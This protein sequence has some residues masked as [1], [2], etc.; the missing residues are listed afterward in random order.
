MMDVGIVGTVNRHWNTVSQVCPRTVIDTV[1]MAL[2]VDQLT[3]LLI[4]N[5]RTVHTVRISSNDVGELVERIIPILP[6]LV[7]LE[8]LAFFSAAKDGTVFLNNGALKDVEQ[9]IVSGKKS[10]ILGCD[11]S[12][13][14]VEKLIIEMAPQLN[15]L[16]FLRGCDSLLKTDKQILNFLETNID[17][18]KINCLYLGHC[19]GGAELDPVIALLLSKASNLQYIQWSNAGASLEM[20]RALMSAEPKIHCAFEGA[21]FLSLFYR[22]V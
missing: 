7:K 15:T 22:M 5:R 16:V 10:L 13:P 6:Q 4:A 19:S 2:S 9:Y 17:I 8:N 11:P 14:A 20:M 18:E 12:L 21:G 3:A 1:G